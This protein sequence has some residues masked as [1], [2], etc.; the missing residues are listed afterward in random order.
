MKNTYFVYIV[1]C[2][3]N[4]L[5]T[6]ITT[7]IERRFSE[8]KTGNGGKYTRSHKVVEILYKE[9]LTD[10]SS[11]LKREVEIKS[12]TRKKKLDLIES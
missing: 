3:N 4:S 5:Y 11:A 10:R 12:W 7:N 8:H 1:R 6:G 9:K 2:K